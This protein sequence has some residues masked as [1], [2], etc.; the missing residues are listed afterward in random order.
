MELDFSPR[1]G[2]RL[3]RTGN[4]AAESSQIF[5]RAYGRTCVAKVAPGVRTRGSEPGGGTGAAPY[6]PAS[7]L[8]AGKV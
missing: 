1:L 3:D 5:R 7:A 4:S 2:A 8:R 6:A